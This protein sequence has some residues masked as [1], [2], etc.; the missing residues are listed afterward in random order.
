MA[1]N[2]LT[3]W[4]QFARR[5]CPYDAT[6]NGGLGMITGRWAAINSS[7]IA[8]LPSAGQG[9]TYL[10]LEGNVQPDPTVTTTIGGSPGYV[11]APLVSL[12]S[13]VASGAAALAYGIFRFAVDIEGFDPGT[14]NAVGQALMVDAVG[15]LVLRTGS[16]VIVA[17]VEAVTSTNLVARTTGA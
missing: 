3:P 16:N 17:Y 15:R 5:S 7:G 4:N 14:V 10:V 1:L 2:P 6:A 13:S 8:T 12:P 11:P 9:G